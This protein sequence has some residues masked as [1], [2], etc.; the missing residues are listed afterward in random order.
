MSALGA[1]S[2]L[3][4]GVPANP[5]TVLAYQ[6]QQALGLGATPLVVKQGRTGA[7]CFLR[8]GADGAKAL[9]AGSA[10]IFGVRV[11]ISATPAPAGAAGAAA[12]VL[13]RVRLALLG[14]R[15]GDAIAAPLH[16]YYSIDVMK[17]HLLAHW[18]APQ[19]RRYAC[20]PPELQ[21]K[22]PDSWSY[23]EA[24]DPD[25]PAIDIVHEKKPHWKSPGA[26]YHSEL[27]AGEVTHAVALANL[28][29]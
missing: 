7:R 16:W 2:V 22:H 3:L 5:P 13:E 20:V 11:G 27:A 4:S 18:G 1:A 14:M 26:F 12:D 17:Q 8:S 9:A 25:E 24:F 29:A 10:L 23:M 21:G 28:L 6:L 19:L 15:A